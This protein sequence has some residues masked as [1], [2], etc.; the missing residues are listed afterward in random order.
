MGMARISNPGGR[1]EG[2]ALRMEESMI[3]ICC[4]HFAGPTLRDGSPHPAPGVPLPTIADPLPCARGYHGSERLIDALIYAPGPW[5]A[6]VELSGTVIP[7][8]TPTD[9]HAA[10]DR[11]GLTP[12][13]DI[14]DVLVQFARTCALRALRIHA[15]A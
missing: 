2:R 6:Q 13:I 1:A 15:P 14:S 8:G 4:W 3:K 5:L 9:K 11:V 12:Y 10:S 7:H